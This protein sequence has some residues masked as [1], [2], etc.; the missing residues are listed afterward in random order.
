MI[1]RTTVATFAGDAG[2]LASSATST[3][4][5]S[6]SEGGTTGTKGH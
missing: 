5:K 6:V 2:H 3:V 1:G 4:G